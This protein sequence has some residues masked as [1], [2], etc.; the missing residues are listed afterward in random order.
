[1]SL[2]LF[3]IPNA[4]ASE[5]SIEGVWLTGNGEGWIE[6]KM[7]DGQPSGFIAGSPQDPENLEPPALDE[8]NP[9]PALRGRPL[10]GL[11]ILHSLRPSR[12]NV[13]KGRIYDP[14]SGKTYKC[15]LT[16]VDTDTLKLRGYI[17]IS[18]FGRTQVWTRRQK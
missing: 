3:A 1:M 2:A 9:D 16:V 6:I 4:A 18:L 17:G 8:K 7:Q 10:F 5:L 12:E 15:V 11:E 13:W 14:N